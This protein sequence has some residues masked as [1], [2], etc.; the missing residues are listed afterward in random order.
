[1]ADRIIKSD[2]GNDTVIQNNSGSRKIKVTNAGD[3]EVTG[4]FKATTVKATNLKA[5]DGTAS[6]EV[7]DSTGD[8]GFSGNTDLKIKLPSAGGIY[9]S[10]GSTE[11]L[12]E[13]SGAVSLKNTAIDSSVTMS[14][15]QSAVK[16]AL[17]ASGSAPIFA[18]RAWV[19]FNGT[20]T[21]AIRDSGNVSSITDE[22]TGHYTTNFTTAMS[23]ANYAI[24]HIY[25]PDNTSA[26]AS[27]RMLF[28]NTQVAGSFDIF[29]R[30]MGGSNTDYPTICLAIFS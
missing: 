3:V 25:K 29:T 6:I 16:T 21:V 15:N 8:I 13:S 22:G 19:N 14:A 24:T 12:T 23:D 9:E 18:C 20:G 27:T 28:F 30:A 10:D 5:N 17:N 26:S 7:A 11:I 2:S 1:M 4:D